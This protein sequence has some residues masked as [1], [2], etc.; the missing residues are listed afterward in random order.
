MYWTTSLFTALISFGLWNPKYRI[1]GNL[2]DY[3]DTDAVKPH[4]DI[5]T[6]TKHPI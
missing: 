4:K 3:G 2:K 6:K 5:I 1:S